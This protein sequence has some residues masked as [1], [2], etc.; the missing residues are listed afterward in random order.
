MKYRISQYKPYIV[1]SICLVL[2]NNPLKIQGQ[3][4]STVID[5]VVAIVG[6]NPILLSD[7]EIGRASCRERV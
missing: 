5:E 1:L 7:I 4:Q 2:L 6:K 3:Q